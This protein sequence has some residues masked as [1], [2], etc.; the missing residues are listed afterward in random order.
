MFLI[1]VIRSRMHAQTVA[2]SNPMPPNMNQ[3]EWL[4]RK[5]MEEVAE[6]LI[7]PSVAELSDILAVLKGLAKHELNTTWNEIQVENETRTRECG[8][9]QSDS[10]QGLWVHDA[11]VEEKMTDLQRQVQRTKRID[12]EQEFLN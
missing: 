3:A 12:S 11:A 1:K 8:D 4:K 7:S 9:F 2:Y 5:L 10:L 6:Y